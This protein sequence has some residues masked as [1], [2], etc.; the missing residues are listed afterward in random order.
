MNA[1]ELRAVHSYVLNYLYVFMF[2]NDMINR[3]LASEIFSFIHRKFNEKARI[4]HYDDGGGENRFMEKRKYTMLSGRGTE[5]PLIIRFLGLNELDW[6]L[7]Q[8]TSSIVFEL[9]QKRNTSDSM[10]QTMSN[11]YVKLKIDDSHVNIPKANCGDEYKCQWEKLA[12][13]IEERIFSSEELD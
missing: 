13:I 4:L 2:G 7:P 1:E 8:F 9:Y 12:K 5:I 6:I 3:I 10:Q 11:Y